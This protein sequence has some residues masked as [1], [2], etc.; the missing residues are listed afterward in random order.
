MIISTAEI[1]KRNL[2]SR[3]KGTEVWFHEVIMSPASDENAKWGYYGSAQEAA[4]MGWPRPGEEAA[5]L[6]GEDCTPNLVLA[7]E[8]KQGQAEPLS[9]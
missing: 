2:K 3:E 9:I 6:P 1:A 5:S 8:K 7:G 4:C